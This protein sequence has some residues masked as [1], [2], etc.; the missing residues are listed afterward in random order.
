MTEQKGWS[1]D[2]RTHSRIF[3]NINKLRKSGHLCDV[4]LKCQDRQFHA[5]RVILSAC[6]DYFCAMF[7]NEVAKLASHLNCLFNTSKTFFS[8][9]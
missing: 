4:V 9:R 1:L 8:T 6:S 3:E 2:E 7:T 5:H